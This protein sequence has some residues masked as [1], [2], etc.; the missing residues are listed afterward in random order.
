MHLSKNTKLRRY[1]SY[2]RYARDIIFCVLES[3]WCIHMGELSCH[4]TFLSVKYAEKSKLFETTMQIVMKY[5][6]I[7]KI[8]VSV[9]L[10][11]N[12]NERQSFYISVIPIECNISKS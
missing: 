2:R 7:V 4:H 1:I 3:I 8:S 6:I 11:T 5:A 12:S 9:M 10:G